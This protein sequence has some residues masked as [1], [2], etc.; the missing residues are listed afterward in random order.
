[1]LLDE[2]RSNLFTPKLVAK[3]LSLISMQLLENTTDKSFTYY[4]M[5]IPFDL[6]F[7]LLECPDI[8]NTLALLE[9]HIYQRRL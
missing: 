1:M 7:D 6:L 5:T 8:F 3:I 9:I 2:T 4:R